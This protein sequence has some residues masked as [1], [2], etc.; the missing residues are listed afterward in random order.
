M[1]NI[2]KKGYIL[3][4]GT[5]Y[6]ASIVLY[7]ISIID[8]NALIGTVISIATLYFGAL[9]LRIENDILFKELFL[10]FN[11]RYDSDMNDLFNRL[12][13]DQ[14]R[15]LEPSERN[16][17]INYFNLCAEEYLWKTKGRIPK[18]VWC[19][20]RAGIIENLSIAQVK[21]AFMDETS[22]EAGKTS[23]YGLYKEVIKYL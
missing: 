16:V 18:D 22:S 6:A 14:S 11:K 1:Q 20:W 17:V 15:P 8:T 9:K 7:S 2:I 10:S 23:Y 3:F 4:F 13:Q 12:K 5:L 21:Q 19:A